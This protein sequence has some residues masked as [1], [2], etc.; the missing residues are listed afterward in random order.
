V[1]VHHLPGPRF[2]K[3]TSLQAAHVARAAAERAGHTLYLQLVVP[4]GETSEALKDMNEE[5]G[6]LFGIA[7][8]EVL[9]DKE[10][11]YQQTRAAAAS[12]RS[13]GTLDEALASFVE[14]MPLPEGIERL[15]V[16]ERSRGYLKAGRA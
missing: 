9:V 2:V 6:A 16:L 10:A 13:E 14:Q 3:A 5:S 1:S 7:G 8:A 4:P 12:A 15:A 11:S